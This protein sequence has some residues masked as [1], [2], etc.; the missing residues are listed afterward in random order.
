MSSILAIDVGGTKTLLASFSAKGEVVEKLKFPTPTDYSEF[1]SELTKAVAS[2][3][4]KKFEKCVI[5]MPGTIDRKAGIALEFGNLPWHDI[6]IVS[7]LQAILDIPV[8]VENDAKLAGLS[9]AHLLPNYRKVLYVTVST[10]IGG[11]LVINGKLDPNSLEAEYGHMLLEHEG[12]LQRWEHFASGKAI[13]EKYGLR[14]SDITDQGTWYA[15]SRNIAI[16]LIDVIAATTPDVIVIGGG[17]GS[18]FGKFGE[19]LTAELK[20]YEDNL[21]HVPPVFGAKRA[22]EA[23][24]YGCY[25]LANQ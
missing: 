24:I 7:D 10:G 2:L 20:L 5:A 9:E 17:V 1:V 19:K 21:L 15:I 18:N 4:T 3:A 8:R 11:G 22:E 23:V 25:I 16:G 13:V 12:K 6:P 14:A